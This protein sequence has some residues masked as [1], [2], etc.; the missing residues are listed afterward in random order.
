LLPEIPTLVELGYPGMAM[1]NIFAMLAPKGTP[2]PVVDQLNALVRRA[3]A[4]PQLNQ[5]LTAQ[6]APPRPTTPEGLAEL[7]ARD[8][9]F[10]EKNVRELK[11]PPID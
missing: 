8:S 4:D 10:F 6:G 3:L 5:R 1:D 7:L 9:A 11:I 2:R